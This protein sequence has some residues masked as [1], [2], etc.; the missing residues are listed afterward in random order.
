[1]TESSLFFTAGEVCSS[2][3]EHRD[4]TAELNHLVKLQAGIERG[5]YVERADQ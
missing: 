5:L 2:V 1:M 3:S 4:K